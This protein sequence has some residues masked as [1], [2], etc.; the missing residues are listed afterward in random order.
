MAE[1]AAFTPGG[2]ALAD[3]AWAAGN[4]SAFPPAVLVALPP[5]EAF[6]FR[7]LF[8][9]ATF[10]PPRDG[11]GD[12]LESELLEPLEYE[13]LD[14]ERLDPD[15]REE[16]DDDPDEDDRLDAEDSDE[17]LLFFRRARPVRAQGST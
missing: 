4:L 15:D 8:L 2:V 10:L 3:F 12:L 11:D 17:L 16:D 13:D 7:T 14:D 5:A 9:M 6:F 1:G